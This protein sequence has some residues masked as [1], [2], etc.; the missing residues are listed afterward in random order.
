MQAANGGF[1]SAPWGEGDSAKPTLRTTRTA[2]RAYRMLNGK[3]PNREKIIDFMKSC[4]DPQSGGFSSEPGGVPDPISTS[5]ALMIFGELELPVAPYLERSLQFMND[6]THGFEQV[7]MV[8]SSLEELDRTVPNAPKWLAEIRRAQNADGSFG[9]GLGQ[10]RTTALNVVA[11]MRLGLPTVPEPVVEV[12]RKGQR[13]D[14]GFGSDKLGSSDLESCY[15]IVRLFHRL[16]TS[17]NHPERLRQFIDSCRNEDGGYGRTPDEKSSLHG[18]YYATIIRAWL[19][20]LSSQ[21]HRKWDFESM[22]PDALP[23]GWKQAMTLRAQAGSQWKVESDELRPTNHLL[24]QS[25]SAGEKKQFNLCIANE[26]RQDLSLSVKLRA[27]SGMIDRGGGLVWR[28]LDPGNYYIMRWNPLEMNLR[29]YKVVDGVRTQL[30][31]A[32]A[33]GDPNVWHSIKIV[34][35]GRDIRGYFDEKLLTEAEDDQFADAGAIG[36][37]T[38]ADAVTE[39]DDLSMTSAW[40]EMIAELK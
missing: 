8:A 3:P 29:L 37:W 11:E 6:H 17:P 28:Y 16:G 19:A 38:K 18:T 40:K 7:R 22:A 5:V 2:L 14:G 1:M 20:D 33:P 12:L 36:L 30:D 26:S 10:A 4:Y 25:S 32:E 24:V 13:N 9:S 31:T 35:V 15:R 34:T 21:V 39:F 27:K 23:A